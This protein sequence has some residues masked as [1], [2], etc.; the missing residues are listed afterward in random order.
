[1]K[2]YAVLH[3]VCGLG[4]GY[5]DTSVDFFTSMDEAIKKKGNLVANLMN[6]D[7]AEAC[8]TSTDGT[9]SVITFND[10][11]HEQ[12]TVRVIE[13][14]TMFD[15][16][17]FREYLVWD[18]MN[19]EAPFGGEY[20]PS[21]MA[22]IKDL[23]ERLE[24]VCDVVNIDILHEFIRDLWYQ[25]D[26]MFDADDICMHYFRIPKSKFTDELNALKYPKQ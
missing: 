10:D 7:Y 13:C 21:D 19:C 9:E 22:V 25:G 1:M 18:Q 6:L 15:D 12:E 2:L 4:E 8:V 23:C 26:A 5:S 14:D 11:D 3:G 20:L 16:Q 17:E 24:S